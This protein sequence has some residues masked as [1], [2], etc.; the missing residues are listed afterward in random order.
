MMVLLVVVGDPAE[1][2][3]EGAVGPGEIEGTSKIR[4]PGEMEGPGELQG[5]GRVAGCKGS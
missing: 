1:A 2:R 3:S 5:T 4:R